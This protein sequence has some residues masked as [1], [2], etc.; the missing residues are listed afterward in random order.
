MC[1]QLVASYLRHRFVPAL[2]RPVHTVVVE[3]DDSV[4]REP[5]VGLE[6]GR[7]A[8]E[9]LLECREGVVGAVRPSTSMRK[10][11]KRRPR[12]HAGNR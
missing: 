3:D 9:R 2:R 8:A 11:V 6:A 1:R 7:P 12:V 10:R 4:S 5:C